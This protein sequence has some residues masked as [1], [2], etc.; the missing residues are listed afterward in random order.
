MGDS[1]KTDVNKKVSENENINEFE[2]LQKQLDE[3]I[4]K[5]NAEHAA[6]EEIDY[7]PDSQHRLDD[8]VDDLQKQMDDFVKQSQQQ[9][10]VKAV[11]SPPGQNKA[12]AKPAPAKNVGKKVKK[13]K[14]VVQQKSVEADSR[15]ANPGK[16]TNTNPRFLTAGGLIIAVVIW[17]VWPDSTE[18][19]PESP[20]PGQQHMAETKAVLAD[21]VAV[22]SIEPVAE[23]EQQLATVAAEPVNAE[24]VSHT[25]N[26]ETDI[27]IEPAKQEAAVATPAIAP[28]VA[29]TAP[30]ATVN[31]TTLTVTATIANIRS[32]PNARADVLH[33]L[34]QG[35]K[36]F[37]I[38]REGDWVQ[39]RI[40]GKL[41][42]A[43]HSVF[44][45][46][47]AAPVA[48]VTKP[49]AEPVT[50]TQPVSSA[51]DGVYQN[52]VVKVASILG[53]VRREPNTG[54]E[55]MFR[56]KQGTRVFAIK[57]EGD[58]VQV[59]IKGV[60]AWAHYSIF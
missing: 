29:A 25:G 15:A 54:A 30:V 24:K 34:K 5:E 40:K 60:E 47:T 56:L 31:N 20:M 58:W 23:Q 41:V 57:R 45:S 52:R 2:A 39:L 16:T 22:E 1:H 10:T 7:G 12:V 32:E 48:V 46:K 50:E 42:W 43:H 51:S 44:A 35:I 49:E 18:I 28:V 21:P 26:K 59:R 17:I 37:A 19:P 53:N 3:F 14:P 13:Q 38:K 33:R 36:V 55:I 8:F 9:K 6:V 27:K 4:E 11:A